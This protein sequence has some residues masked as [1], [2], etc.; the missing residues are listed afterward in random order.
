MNAPTRAHRP[1]E[2]LISTS[3][4]CIGL[5]VH[6][7]LPWTEHPFSFSS[8][9]IKNQEQIAAI[10]SLGLERIHYSPDKSSVEPLAALPEK[11][12]ALPVVESPPTRPAF[13][14]KVDRLER[15]AAHHAKIEACERTLLSNARSVKSINQSLFSQPSEAL[16][17]AVLLVDSMASS[18]LVDADMVIQL[19]AVKAGADDTY[20]HALNVTIMSM[21]LAK[22]MKAPASAMKLVGLGALLHDIG[23]NDIPARILRKTSALTTTELGVL[24]QHCAGG[25]AIATRMG[26]PPEALLIIEQHHER[27]DGTGYPKKLQ[28]AQLNL[29]SKIVA[30]VNTYD[31]LCNPF[32]PA[33]ALTPHESLAIIYGQQRAHFDANVMATFV[34]SVGIYPPGTVVVLS[35]GTIGLVTSVNASKPLKPTVLVYDPAIPKEAAMVVDLEQE[36]DVT[37]ANALNP[38]TLPEAVQDYL[39]PRRRITYYFDMELSKAAG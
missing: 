3:Q 39:S 33:H 19:M 17:E 2:H 20:N 21:M 1:G 5:Y 4:L 34:R 9:R 14:G 8:F 22:E 38:L 25:V 30:L 11:A 10:Q 15:V 32:D 36:S 18:M 35:N 6:L 24:Q 27:V 12:P 7:D 26:A 16:K 13:Q 29:L 28:G 31:N 37:I 23:K